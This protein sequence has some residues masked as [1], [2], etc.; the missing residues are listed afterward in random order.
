M[1]GVAEELVALYSVQPGQVKNQLL[2]LARTDVGAFTHVATSLIQT[3]DARAVRLVADSLLSANLFELFLSNPDLKVEEAVALARQAC[4]MDEAASLRLAKYLV[5]EAE[6][7]LSE[8]RAL[9][10]LEVLGSVSPPDRLRPLLPKLLQHPSPWIR[11]KV[12]LLL[13]LNLANG[14]DLAEPDP[15]VRANAIEAMWRTPGPDRREVF[16]R[17]LH[18]PNNRVVGN[19][20]LGLYRAGDPQAIAPLV[21]MATHPAPAYRATAA[22]VIGET[23]DPRFTDC[24]SALLKD[25]DQRTRMHAFR[26]LAKLRNRRRQCEQAGSLYVIPMGP[27]T[28]QNGLRTVN[29]AVLTQHG[30]PVQHLSPLSFVLRE[31]PQLVNEY[32]LEQRCLIEPVIASFFFFGPDRPDFLAWAEN[33][34]AAAERYKKPQDLWAALRYCPAG[35]ELESQETLRDFDVLRITQVRTPASSAQ[36]S[37]PFQH[38]NIPALAKQSLAKA[39]STFSPWKAL[40]ESLQGSANYEG[41]GN[42]FLAAPDWSALSACHPKDRTYQANVRAWCSA[43]GAVLH[44]IAERDHGD[45]EAIRRLCEETGGLC[46]A[47]SQPADFS[48]PAA[49]YASLSCHY[50]LRYNQPA[51][52]DGAILHVELFSDR[53]Y[54]KIMVPLVERHDS[55]A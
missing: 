42:I 40:S 30:E 39:Y 22:W 45:Q 3:G 31:G 47:L 33:L 10:L 24:L 20:I 17:A 6:C 53:G 19:A 11:S 14:W 18:D 26:S 25:S 34:L 55:A 29:L 32:A 4:Q 46:L 51:S 7:G 49:I 9:R 21:Q 35:A 15:R 5:R 48:L 44:A 23:G 28:A 8:D 27:A 37:P 52:A 38:I 2:S 50:R 36:N 13:R 41:L 43:A 12:A 16:R 54:G 1:Q